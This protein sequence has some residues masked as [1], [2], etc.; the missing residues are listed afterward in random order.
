MSVQYI[1][2]T[3][4]PSQNT[5]NDQTVLLMFSNMK[6]ITGKKEILISSFNYLKQSPASKG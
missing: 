6:L 5:E 1:I 2:H 3:S 4:I